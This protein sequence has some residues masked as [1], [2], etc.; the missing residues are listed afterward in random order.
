MDIFDIHDEQDFRKKA[1]SIFRYQAQ[2]NIVYKKFIELLRI[3]LSFCEGQ[4]DPT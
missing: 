4:V 1:L 2:N 3:V